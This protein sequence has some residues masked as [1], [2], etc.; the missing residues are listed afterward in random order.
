A[1][2]A[3]SGAAP[4]NAPSALVPAPVRSVDAEAVPPAAPLIAAGRGKFI[5]PIKG[6]ILSTY[7]PKG[8]GQRNDGVNIAATEGEPVR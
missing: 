7:G 5:W 2:A 6:D 4:A 1:S 8:P 3:Q